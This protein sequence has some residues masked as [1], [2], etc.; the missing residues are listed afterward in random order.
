MSVVLCEKN[1]ERFYEKINRLNPLDDE[2]SYSI[3]LAKFDEANN[4]I[5]YFIESSGTGFYGYS[6]TPYGLDAILTMRIESV[7]FDDITLDSIVF[8]DIVSIK[9]IPLSSHF[10]I[11]FRIKDYY[12]TDEGCNGILNEL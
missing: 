4:L 3:N 5:R 12:R 8:P 10:Q 7:F 6:L 11:K 2:Y 9:I 1:V